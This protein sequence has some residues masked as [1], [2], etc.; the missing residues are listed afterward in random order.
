VPIGIAS[1]EIASICSHD[2]GYERKAVSVYATNTSTR[3]RIMHQLSVSVYVPKRAAVQRTLNLKT[4]SVHAV[5]TAAEN[6]HC[7]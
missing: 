2:S 7:V 1:E 3:Q 5:K 4:V 6:G